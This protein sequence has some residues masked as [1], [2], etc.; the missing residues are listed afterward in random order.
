VSDIA[1]V[2]PVEWVRFTFPGPALDPRVIPPLKA[3]VDPGTVR[4]LDAAV[5]HKN[6]VGGGWLR[7]ISGH[8]RRRPAAPPWGGAAGLCLEPLGDS[9]GT[10]GQGG[11]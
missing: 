7:R 3:L 6:A 2:G 11:S 4:L 9:P 8:G 5:L 10:G 1:T